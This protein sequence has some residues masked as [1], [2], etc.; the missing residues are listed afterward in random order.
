M[1]RSCNKT[2]ETC[3][4]TTWVKITTSLAETTT[5]ATTT[6]VTTTTAATTTPTVTTKDSEYKTV[7]CKDIKHPSL[8]KDFFWKRKTF[9]YFT[10]KKIF[11]YV[12]KRNLEKQYI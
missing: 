4:G 6:T 9:H 5:T 1:E 7:P 10:L 3:T 12:L 11:L 8:V 2:C